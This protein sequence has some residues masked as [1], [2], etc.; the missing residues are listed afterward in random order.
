MVMDDS[1]WLRAAEAQTEFEG[2]LVGFVVSR[3]AGGQIFL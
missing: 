2:S 3:V 1:W